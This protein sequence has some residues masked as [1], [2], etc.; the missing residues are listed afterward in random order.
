MLFNYA[1]N[2]FSKKFAK[3]GNMVSSIS[4][5]KLIQKVTVLSVFMTAYFIASIFN[6]DFWGNIL[7]PINAFAMAGTLYFSY[8]KADH[9][10]RERVTLLL[11]AVACI[12]WGIADIIWAGISFA[13]GAPEDSS[14]IAVLYV[15]TNFFFVLSLIVFLVQQFHKWDLVQFGIDVFISSF[16]CIVLLWILFLHKDVNILKQILQ[17]DY[18][19]IFSIVT[20]IIIGSTIISWF[21]SAR[22]GEIPVFLVIITTGLFLFAFVDMLYYYVD[23]NGLYVSNSLLD[24]FYIL[25]FFVIAFGALWKTYKSDSAF[26]IS[27]MTNIGT[28]KRWMFLLLF[29][30]VMLLVTATGIIPVSLSAGDYIEVVVPILFYWAASNYIQ[31]SLEKEALLQQSNEML[32]KRVAEQ[33]SELSFLANQDTLT[34]LFN[35]R[36]LMTYLD[37]TLK[38][39]RQNEL[40]ALFLIDVD[41][42]KTIN[43]TFGH[44]TGDKVLI[45]LSCR[46]TE[47]N[48]C[49][50]TIARLGGDEF[51]VMLVGKYTQKEVEK[52]CEEMITSCSKSISIGD[53]ELVLTMSV[54]IALTSEEV[55]DRKKLLQNAD[56]AMYRSKS[57]GY[58]K[59][60]VY[61][62]IMS[63]DFNKAAEVEILLRQVDIDKDFELFYQPQYALPDKELI[64]AEALLRWKHPDHGY[65]PPNVF[66]PI[67][68]Q[69]DYI[70][71]IGKWV[72][73][74]TIEQSMTWNKKYQIPLKIGF[75]I[76]PKQIMDTGFI[77][78]IK[79]LVVDNNITPAWIDAEITEGLMINDGDNINE[80]FSA[81]G[82]LKI[83]VSIDDFGSGY[84]SLGYLNK[85]HFDR[86]KIDKSLI[87][88]VNQRNIGGTNVVKAIINMAHASNIQALA[89]GVETQEQLNILAELGCDQIQG[90]LWG[91]PVPAGVFEQRYIRSC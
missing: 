16:L 75:N 58:N 82:D 86:I 72:I 88:N 90:Y 20:D 80:M 44:D 36:Y 6:S 59:Y 77:D 29:P 32:E 41:R 79:T 5:R 63:Q 91:R 65:I 42:F 19:S 57:Q 60:Q 38:E 9:T 2:I 83:S 40:I 15:Q 84:S 69:I 23:Y 3:G 56:I 37:D 85:Y 68:E 64:G 50:A 71:K 46:L 43:D 17:L 25:S 67:A 27:M 74:K 39:M 30:L 14:I 76:S 21:I 62:P 7:S 33:V 66:I 78:L 87:D 18:T 51:A 4:K 28:K 89:E 48:N 49:G 45:D 1:H 61:D 31:I 13:G 24:F 70:Y 22:S 8:L 55:R 53:R 34:T 35:R 52:L 47:W 54:G 10:V 11:Y 73:Q 12:F 26:D 81:F